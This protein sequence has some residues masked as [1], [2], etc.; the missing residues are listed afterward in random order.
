M[1]CGILMPLVSFFIARELC[2]DRRI[3]LAAALL[4]AVN[5][6]IIDM[7]VQVQR[8][9]PYLFAVGWTIYLLIAAIRRNNWYW[10]CG[11]GATFAVAFLIRYETSEFLPLLGIYFVVTLLFRRT[12]WKVALRNCLLFCLCA[13]IG[14]AVLLG[15]SGTGSS[16]AQGVKERVIEHFGLPASEEVKK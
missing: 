14:T 9:V 10:W 7:A 3:A 16:I 4:T 5:P 6:S 1:G 15:I 12:Q 8:D 2:S 13:L 11:A